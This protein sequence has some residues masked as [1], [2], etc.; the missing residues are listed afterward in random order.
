MEIGFF[1]T[2]YL[3]F[4]ITFASPVENSHNCF[5]LTLKLFLENFLILSFSSI[6]CQLPYLKQTFI[7]VSLR[8]STLCRYYWYTTTTTHIL[9]FSVKIKSSK[10]S[11][12]LPGRASRM[13]KHWGLYWLYDDNPIIFI[14]WM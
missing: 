4:V 10:F 12:L 8:L 5:P 13:T 7:S 1:F 6:I 14:F 9:I 3:Y 11:C 2:E